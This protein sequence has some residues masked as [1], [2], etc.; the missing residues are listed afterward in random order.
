MPGGGVCTR[1]FVSLPP[2]PTGTVR[3][4][5][6]AN[7]LARRA[8]AGNAM[9]MRSEELTAATL[10][11]G[12]RL[13][14]FKGIFIEDTDD[15]LP[16][17]ID[18]IKAPPDLDRAARTID[19]LCVTTTMEVGVDIASTESGVQTN[20]PPQRFNYQQRVGHAGRRG[21]PSPWL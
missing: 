19:V 7:Y 12:S 15:I 4:L 18:R 6:K 9:R 8:L 20:M 10:N 21:Q 3:E 14:R 11:P 5:R 17:G 1:C 2:N 16:V 13:R